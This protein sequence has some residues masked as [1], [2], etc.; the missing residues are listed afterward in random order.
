MRVGVVAARVAVRPVQVVNADRQRSRPEEVVEPLPCAQVRG[1]ARDG[2][3]VVQHLVHTAPLGVEH[4]LPR[5]L[6]KAR[7]R[8]ERP[9]LTHHPVGHPQQH[10]QGLPVARV[11]V[12]VQH[13]RHHLVHDVERHAHGGAVQVLAG[14]GVAKEVVEGVEGVR[15][16]V[17]DVAAAERAPRR[18]CLGERG[19]DSRALVPHRCPGRRRGGG[20]G[21]R[22]G[23]EPVPEVVTVVAR[24]AVGDARGGQV[25]R[26]RVQAREAIVL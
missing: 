1:V 24:V 3:Q 2:V 17:A 25:R 16:Q 5:G 13:A 6:A 14:L 22:G 11:L 4:L 21:E 26:R 18:L 8:E 7:A 10:A 15:K 20:D 9:D 19:D 12:L 23:G